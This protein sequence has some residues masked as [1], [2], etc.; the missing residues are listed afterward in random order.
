[1]KSLN[2]QLRELSKR[3]FSVASMGGTELLSS[4]DVEL[5]NATMKEYSPVIEWLLDPYSYTA[6]GRSY[7]M[8]RVFVE[9]GLKHLGKPIYA[10]DHFPIGMTQEHMIRTVERLLRQDERVEDFT[11]NKL[12]FTVTKRKET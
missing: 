8:A 4:S 3:I 2:K 12:S 5:L 1:M 6:T 10:F 9:L 7:I 11:I